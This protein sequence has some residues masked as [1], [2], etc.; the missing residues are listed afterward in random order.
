MEFPV[1]TYEA[2]IIA[3]PQL[4][5]QALEQLKVQLAEVISRQGGRVTENLLLGKRKL[6]HLIRKTGDGV[7]LQIRFEVASGQIAKI[8]KA[9]ALI[10]SV[11]RMMVILPTAGDAAAGQKVAS[12]KE[13]VPPKPEE[14]VP[15]RE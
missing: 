14:A 4:S 3:S 8:Q 5:D 2:M 15:G 13:G 11:F 7:Y 12:E 9:V 6:A 10:E 1:R